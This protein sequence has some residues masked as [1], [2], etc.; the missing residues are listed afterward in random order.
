M[1]IPQWSSDLI[2]LL[3]VIESN[4]STLHEFRRSFEAGKKQKQVHPQLEKIYQESLPHLNEES[5]V[6][7]FDNQGFKL[8]LGLKTISFKSFNLPSFKLY[9][10][11]VFSN[12]DPNLRIE[13]PST[14]KNAFSVKT[15][16]D[17]I[18]RMNTMSDSEL[19]SVISKVPREELAKVIVPDNMF[20]NDESKELANKLA[21]RVRSI[22]Q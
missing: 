12:W 22:A 4:S 8:T 21:E 7:W 5:F 11:Q 13:I 3:K 17:V 19:A 18:S 9:L 2:S 6:S 14:K 1:S 20:Q 10:F 16:R 15:M